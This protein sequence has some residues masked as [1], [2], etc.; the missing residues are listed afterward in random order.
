MP[1]FYRPS[2]A[3]I[4][5][6]HL[7]HNVQQILD[8]YGPTHFLCPMVKA[9]AYGH[10]DI[11][12]SHCLERMGIKTLGV[13][14]IEEGLHLRQNGVS[15]EII[16]F[17]PFPYEG[18]AAAH[19]ANLQL[20]IST[21]KQLKEIVLWT[22]QPIKIH[23]KFDTGMNRFGFTLSDI[24][25]VLIE[26]SSNP[27]LLVCGIATHLLQGEDLGTTANRTSEQLQIF[28]S[29]ESKIQKLHK[30]QV[31]KIEFHAYNS[32][33]ICRTL[34]NH[35][36]LT[37]L[38][39]RPGLMIY[40]YD[41]SVNFHAPLESEGVQFHSSSSFFELKKVMT[42][43]SRISHFR[44]LQKKESVSYNGTWTA[45][46]ESLIGVIQIGYADGMRRNFS[47]GTQVLVNGL[48]API[49]GVICMD[50]LMIDLTDIKSQIKSEPVLN[51]VVF[52]GDSDFGDF[53][54]AYER[55]QDLKT[56]I[57]EVLTSP[58]SRVPRIYKGATS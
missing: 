30:P 35:S 54:S 48:R 37:D 24:E 58:S 34:K 26:V 38:G 6:D 29:L 43:K 42:L 3:E 28:K 11:E 40:G 5:L 41:P 25:K 56:N 13:C 22:H 50:S 44:E 2:V 1:S 10:G 36:P 12:V 32:G 31:S 45:Q 49:I 33:A 14:L 21:W 23:L 16:V 9:N 20:V 19:A 55:A 15:T 18:F 52:W 7:R 46:R 39:L 17:Q 51:E 8:R 27:N 53:I 57:W 47:N 4:N